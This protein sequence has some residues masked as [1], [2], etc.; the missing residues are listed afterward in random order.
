MTR[1]VS[2]DFTGVTQWTAFSNDT[3]AVAG[4]I[5]GLSA[6]TYYLRIQAANPAGDSPE[7]DAVL[8]TSAAPSD[9][10]WTYQ[11]V[12]EPSTIVPGGEDG[13]EVS[14]V[15]TWTTSDNPSEIVTLSANPAPAPPPPGWT[16][17]H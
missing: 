5:R 14:L 10:T 6:G 1:K 11:V 13:A 4:T 15:A 12:V 8:I 17:L 3:D 16:L 2:G 7:S 9:G